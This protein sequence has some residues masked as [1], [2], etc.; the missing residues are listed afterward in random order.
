MLISITAV[1]ILPLLCANCI[2]ILDSFLFLVAQLHF[3]LVSP[4]KACTN[5]HVSRSSI[6]HWF[7]HLTNKREIQINKPHI[8]VASERVSVV[9]AKSNIW[10]YPLW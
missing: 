9:L 7:T 1:P 5:G 4:L 6:M 10:S 8:S 2:K 3:T